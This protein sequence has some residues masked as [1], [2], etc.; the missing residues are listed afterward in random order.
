[1]YIDG[2]LQEQLL[3]VTAVSPTQFVPSHLVNVVVRRFK[4]FGYGIGRVK[5]IDVLILIV[6]YNF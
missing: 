4:C 6:V 1:M 2:T 3:P 5:Q